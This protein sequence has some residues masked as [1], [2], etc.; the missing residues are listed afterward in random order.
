MPFTAQDGRPLFAVKK[1]MPKA[2]T[3]GGKSFDIFGCV[4]RARFDEH[5]RFRRRVEQGRERSVYVKL[6]NGFVEIRT[7]KEDDMQFTVFALAADVRSG[8]GAFEYVGRICVDRSEK[9]IFDRRAFRRIGNEYSV[10]RNFCRQQK[11]R[12]IFFL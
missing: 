5:E 3:F 11:E 8:K 12:C 10:Y 6:Q 2:S 7:A 9:P 1:R 4:R